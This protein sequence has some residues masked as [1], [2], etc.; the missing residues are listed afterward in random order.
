MTKSLAILTLSAA[1]VLS[2]CVK[3]DPDYEA[4]KAEKALLAA[5]T[6]GQD[7]VDVT[8]NEFNPPPSP[9]SDVNINPYAAPTAAPTDGSYLP[10]I[11][12]GGATYNPPSNVNLPALGT[13]TYAN[14]VA[15]EVV[16]GDTLWGLSKQYNVTVADIQAANNMTNDIAV[17]GATLMIP[18]N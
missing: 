14:S 12:G 16:S 7:D 18:Q 6:A 17:L 8:I 9:V 3:T 11:P 10:P 15:H 4:Y 13:N 2:S 5:Q 1:A